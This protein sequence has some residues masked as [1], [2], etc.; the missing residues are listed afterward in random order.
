M[1]PVYEYWCDTH[2]MFEATRP[3]EDF[4]EPSACPTCGDA[5]PR[6]LFTAPGLGASDR[7]SIRAHDVNARSA[8]SPKR[9]TTHGPG[10]GCCSGT[11]KTDSKTLHHANGAKSF[12]SKRPWMIAH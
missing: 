6:V 1:M 5:S 12:P 8:D 7:A 3:M 11:S 2:G 4:R 9:T 10:C